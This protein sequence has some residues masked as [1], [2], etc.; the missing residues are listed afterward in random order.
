MI[1]YKGTK[2]LKCMD[3]TYEVGK[4]YT[5]DGELLACK[6]GFHFCKKLEDVHE[7]YELF[8][9]ETVIL[10]IEVLG[11]II[12][13]ENKSI[14]NKFK[15][16]EIIPKEDYHLYSENIIGNKIKIEDS[17]GDWYSNEYDENGNLIKY[18][19]SNEKKYS[20][21]IE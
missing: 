8:N 18:E 11:K 1:A 9:K 6:Q 19:N 16:I 12:D 15:V 20:I 13:E 17:N 14:T 3:F 5:F 4:T 2:N 7:Y 10:K 21:T